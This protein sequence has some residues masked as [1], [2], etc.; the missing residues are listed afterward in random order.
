MRD[1]RF[2]GPV[3]RAVDGGE[4]LDEEHV[5]KMVDAYKRKYLDYRANVIARTESLRSAVAG[6][7]LGV[8]QLLDSTAM[9]GMT[10][11]RTWMATHDSHTRDS[12]K[13]MDGQTITGMDA[14]YELPD[15]GEIEHPLA[16]GAPAS[17]VIQCRCT[18]AYRIVPEPDDE[19]DD[20]EA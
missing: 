9:E 2:D 1:K 14:S 18:E 11:E 17:E 16:D 10:V 4:P 20:K 8:E 13:A 15:G 19:G 5:N 6:A 12:H 3:Q 7:R